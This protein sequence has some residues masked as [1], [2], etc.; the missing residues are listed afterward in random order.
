MVKIMLHAH[1]Y[2]PCKKYTEENGESKEELQMYQ[3]LF[4][5][6]QMTAVRARAAKKSR[7]NSTD[8]SLCLDGLLPCIEDWHAKVILLEVKKCFVFY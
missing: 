3:L 6:D 2:V 1:G 4:G 8:D 5:G 7:Q